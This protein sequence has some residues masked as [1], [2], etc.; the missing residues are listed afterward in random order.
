MVPIHFIPVTVSPAVKAILTAPI[1]N[2]FSVSDLHR[3]SSLPGP[4]LQRIVRRLPAGLALDVCMADG[5]L[6]QA[7]LDDAAFRDEMYA[8]FKPSDHATLPYSFT[9]VSQQ[10]FAR[11]SHGRAAVLTAATDEMWA[12]VKAALQPRSQAQAP[13][14]RR[15][16]RDPD[17][18]LRENNPIC[19]IGLDTPALWGCEGYRVLLRR[20]A[21]LV[22]ILHVLDKSVGT[23]NRRQAALLTR[24]VG[25]HE[26]ALPD[27][28]DPQAANCNADLVSKTLPLLLNIMRGGERISASRLPHICCLDDIRGRCAAITHNYAAATEYQLLMTIPCGH[29]LRVVCGTD[30]LE[31]PIP[32]LRVRMHSRGGFSHACMCTGH[33]GCRCGSTPIHPFVSRQLCAN[34][35]TC[36]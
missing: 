15:A 14:R 30:I 21:Y 23:S 1:G 26:S 10:T 25:G 36:R 33:T 17:S 27:L 13:K 35:C 29:A 24:I 20:S 9:G 31:L 2:E 5:F 19:R 32:C 6:S 28:F 3:I 7:M 22:D 11:M 4:I 34:A 16:S 8:R 12:P 18:M